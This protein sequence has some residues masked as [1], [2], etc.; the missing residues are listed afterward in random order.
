MKYLNWK[1]WLIGVCIASLI[2]FVSVY[3]EITDHLL[4]NL[5][6]IGVLMFLSALSFHRGH[7]RLGFSIL[8]GLFL[9]VFS[10][11]INLII[12]LVQKLS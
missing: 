3:K 6:L 11:L 10:L 5:L 2:I 1:G 9:G 12:M 4:I 7:I 8:T